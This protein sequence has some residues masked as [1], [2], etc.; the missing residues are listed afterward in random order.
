[1]HMLMKM[2]RVGAQACVGFLGALFL[3]L[4]SAVITTLFGAPDARFLRADTVDM[5]AL[6]EAMKVIF[7]DPLIVN[8]VQDSELQAMFRADG[9]NIRTEETTGGRY[10]EMAHYFR[11][12]TGS[13]SL[14]ENDYLP[15]PR[16]PLFKNSRVYLRKIAGVIEMTGDVM[17]R[18][19][20]DEGAFIN[21]MQRALPDLVEDVVSNKIDRQYIGD[22]SGVKAR[23]KGLPVAA[24]G[25]YT[26]ELEDHSGVDGFTDCWLLFP[27]GDSIVFSAT[28]AGTTLR[29]PGAAQAAIVADS[30]E[31]LDVITVEMDAGLAAV[32]QVG[33]YIFEGDAVGKA[34]QNSGVNREM[35]GLMAAVDD[36]G[37]VDGYNN[38][39][40]TDVG[41]KQWRSLVRDASGAPYNGSVTEQL[42]GS[43]DTEVSTRGAGKID[44]FILSNSAAASFWQNLKKGLINTDPRSY[45]DQGGRPLPAQVFVKDRFVPIKV[46]R[47][48]PPEVFFGLQKDTFRRL[49]LGDWHWINRHGSIWHQVTDG[50]GRK[51]SSYA[52]GIMREELINTHPRKNIRVEGLTP[53]E[54]F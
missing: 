22:G 48:L 41:N 40:R 38:I 39:T 54:G 20:G 13:R 1:M 51:D 52:Y 5:T 23:V 18:V 42:F 10:I 28:V 11:S 2:R 16:N 27:D 34:A 17:D 49:T 7:S 29:N 19:V 36:G 14:S 9:D 43:A 45:V 46:A 8:I 12:A 3:A 37:I 50:T 47:K 44:V 15:V 21:W 30:D 26:I 6:N 4:A 33:D 35:Q 25:Y 24:G 31:D 53:V 32:I